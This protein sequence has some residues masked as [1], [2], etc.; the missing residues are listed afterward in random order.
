MDAHRDEEARLVEVHSVVAALEASAVAL[1]VV[2]G[3]AEAGKHTPNIQE[4]D[5]GAKDGGL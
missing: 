2:E 4:I 1:S 5:L 3:Q